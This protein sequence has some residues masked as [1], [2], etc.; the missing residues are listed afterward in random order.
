MTT[1]LKKAFSLPQPEQERLGAK[2]IAE[3]KAGQIRHQLFR[4]SEEHLETRH[5]NERLL[6]ALNAA[7][8]DMPDAEE[9]TLLRN[10]RRHHRQF[11]KENEQW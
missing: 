6:E 3:I 2:W 9:Q 1:L 11:I 10:M 5:K 8:D 7:Y 4:A